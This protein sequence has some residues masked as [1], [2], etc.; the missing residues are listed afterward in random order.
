MKP[1][2]STAGVSIRLTEIH[3]I[4]S[5]ELWKSMIVH[6]SR[7][8]TPV[9]RMMMMMMMMMMLVVVVVVVV[10]LCDQKF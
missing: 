2:A 10:K 3:E 9:T 7:D 4:E 6:A 1:Y 5:R 8:V